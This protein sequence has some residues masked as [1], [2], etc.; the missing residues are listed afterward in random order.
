M[1]LQNLVRSVR[2]RNSEW[3]DNRIAVKKQRGGWK[4]LSQA[5]CIHSTCSCNSWPQKHLSEHFCGTRNMTY[6]LS[7]VTITHTFIFYTWKEKKASSTPHYR[8]LS[9]YLSVFSMYI[10]L[11][12][13]WFWRKCANQSSKIIL[14]QLIYTT[15]PITSELHQHNI[16][17]IES[18]F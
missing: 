13:T 17:K 16:P 10:C 1:P 2:F 8:L 12:M 18:F 14:E 3:C 9:S 11:F 4:Y 7:M 15:K 6:F 5:K